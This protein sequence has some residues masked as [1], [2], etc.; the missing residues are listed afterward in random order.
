MKYDPRKQFSKWLAR[1]SAVFWFVYL[2]LMAL[3]LVIQPVAADA[4]LYLGI[5]ASV[6]MIVNVWAYTRNSIYEKA[7]RSGV[8]EIGKFRIT[9]KATKQEADNDEEEDLSEEG[10]S[11]G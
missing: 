5:T 9:W 1:S 10:E 6:V 8:K 7:F 3:V 11:N 4:A 2:L